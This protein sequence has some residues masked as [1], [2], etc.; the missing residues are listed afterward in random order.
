MDDGVRRLLAAGMNRRLTTAIFI[1]LALL[2][3]DQ[4]HRPMA[5]SG[6]AQPAVSSDASRPNAVQREMR[7]LHEALRD[8]VTA[9]A[10]GNV[11]S[12]AERLTAI[13][14][15]RQ[16]TE[17]AVETGD[18]KLPKNAGNLGT[19]EQLDDRFHADLENLVAKA[20]VGDATATSAQLGVVLSQCGGCH[21]QFRT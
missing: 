12:I 15:A 3:C 20:K 8:S 14:A 4:T 7:L 9:I 17:R 5:S 13:D 6:D 2:Q 18:Y 19:F 11:E 1:G 10:N 16:V 21:G